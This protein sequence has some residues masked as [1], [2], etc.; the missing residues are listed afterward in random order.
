MLYKV[1]SD[2]VSVK[3]ASIY[4][5]IHGE[6]KPFLLMITGGTGDADS[7][8]TI[9]PYLIDQF[10]IISYDRRGY[11]RSPINTIADDE[12]IGIATQTEDV[13]SLL[14][15]I[16][17]GPVY[18]FG[19]SIGAVIA[20]D[21]GAKYPDLVE[22]VIAHEPPLINQLPD[23]ERTGKV[24]LILPNES[25]M[26]AMRRFTET[27]KLVPRNLLGQSFM[28]VSKD[29]MKRKEADTKF[30]LQ[31]ESKGVDQYLPDIE[32]IKIIRSKI[33]FVAGKESRGNFLYKLAVQTS[34]DIGAEF[35]EMVGHH[36][37]YGQYP[38]E[39]SQQLLEIL[40]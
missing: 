3:N 38:K 14:Q 24:P 1:K 35:V 36:V 22:K 33:V 25:P 40:G 34:K 30:F 20:I 12:I 9:I 4:F 2:N 39:F 32:R 6:G 17:P 10:T 16:T 7:F 26:A 11:T 13:R 28:H 5:K 23:H 19:S 18:I 37:G 8:D 31:H 29:A 15:T 27:F 21:F